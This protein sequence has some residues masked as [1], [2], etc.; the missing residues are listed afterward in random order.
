MLRRASRMAILLLLTPAGSLPA[1]SAY[2]QPIGPEPAVYDACSACPD[3]AVLADIAPPPDATATDAVAKDADAAD[4]PEV[5]FGCVDTALLMYLMTVD[6]KL[7]SFKPDTQTI[8]EIGPVNCP[9]TSGPAFSMALDRNAIAWVLYTDAQHEGAGL[10]RV[11]TADASCQA[12]TFHPGTSGTTPFGTLGPVGLSVFGMGFTRD[13]PG[14]KTESLYVIGG[15]AANFWIST[16]TLAVIH[17]PDMTV[18]E[19]GETDIPGGVE[20]TGSGTGKLYG[21]FSETDQSVASVREIAKSTGKTVGEGW[22]L[23]SAVLPGV[24]A[25]A[26][27]LWGGDFYI[28]AEPSGTQSSNVYKLSPA[29]GKVEEIMKNIGYIVVGAGVSSCAPTGGN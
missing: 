6:G 17:F 11:D 4:A 14:S 26:I 24:G 29:T 28:F 9:K 15:Q 18:T 20:L 21:L 23:S 10:Y 25:Q 7:L 13:A 2:D 3:L 19:L 5:L 8:H 27:G 16:N 12:T 22:H 1:C